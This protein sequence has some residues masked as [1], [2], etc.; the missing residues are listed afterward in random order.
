MTDRDETIGELLGRSLRA[1]GVT[2]VFGSSASGITGISGLGHL[3]VDEPHLA[4]LLADAH[5][6]VSYGRHPGSA[7]LPGRR[8]HIGS[9]PGGPATTVGVP[10]AATL[11]EVVAGFAAGRVFDAPSSSS[12]RG[13][14]S[15]CHRRSR[16]SGS[17]WWP[18]PG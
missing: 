14:R 11:V 1:L 13:R 7:L 8:L 9:Q 5:G 18:G 15:R 3:R 6:R 4:V 17:W 2:R 10:D 16:S 12:R